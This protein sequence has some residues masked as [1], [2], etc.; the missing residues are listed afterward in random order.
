MKR[1]ATVFFIFLVNL[2]LTQLEALNRDYKSDCDGDN[3]YQYYYYP[4][5]LCHAPDN[6][7][8]EINYALLKYIPATGPE[9]RNCYNRSIYLG[10]IDLD[11][12][13]YLPHLNHQ[14]KY[15]S[16][17][18][19]C[20]CLW[21]EYS[22]E[23]AQINDTAYILF[24]D[25]ISTTALSNLITDEIQ[26]REFVDNPCW[27]LNK[28]GLS[29]SFIAQQFRF[30]HYYRVCRDI[31]NFSISKYEERETAKIKDRLQILLEAL[32]LL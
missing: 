17:Y 8:D 6:S 11:F 23:A 22:Q 1:Y 19:D 28:H 20:F 29:I 26:Q 16:Q 5:C 15:S 9:C 2:I 27:F 32:K 25:L 18:T 3:T 24:R 31:E 21:P 10:Y 13:K 14:L 7:P 30:S 12:R 4:Y